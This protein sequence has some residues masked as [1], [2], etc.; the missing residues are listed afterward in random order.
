MEPAPRPPIFEVHIR[1]M[2]RLRDRE[3]MS[4]WVQAFD[5]WDLDAV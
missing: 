1:P 2:F 4:K 3:P 5:L